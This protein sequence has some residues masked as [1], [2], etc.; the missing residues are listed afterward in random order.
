MDLLC[1]DIPHCLGLLPSSQNR[2]DS[3]GSQMCEYGTVFHWEHLSLEH[4]FSIQ[5]LHKKIFARIEYTCYHAADLSH[6]HTA[7]VSTVQ[8]GGFFGATIISCSEGEE[9]RSMIWWMEPGHVIRKSCMI[10]ADDLSTFIR[11]G[12]RDIFFILCRSGASILLYRKTSLQVAYEHETLT[13]LSRILSLERRLKQMQHLL[14]ASTGCL[15]SALKQ[16]SWR[17]LSR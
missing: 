12:H 11:L 16:W 2:Q 17:H 7:R 13:C 5:I 6:A 15:H 8:T 1:I 4:L 10:R 9:T 3:S 14:E